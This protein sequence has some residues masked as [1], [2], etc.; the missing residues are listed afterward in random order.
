MFQKRLNMLIAILTLPLILLFLNVSQTLANTVAFSGGEL[1]GKP[2]D[3]SITINIVPDNAIQYYYEYGTTSGVY[4][5]ETSPVDAAAD[6]PHETVIDGLSSNT[7]YYYRMVYDGDGSVTDG[8]FETRDEHQFCTQGAKGESFVFTVTSDSHAQYNTQYQQ[9]MINV[10]SDNPDFHLD[11]GDTFMPDGDANQAAVDT[12]YMAQRSTLYMGRIGPSVPIFL[13]PGN[14]EDKEGWNLDDTPFSIG[15]GSIQARKAYFPTPTNEG[16]YSGNTDPLAAIDDVTYGDDLREDYYAWT[17]GDALFV[18]IDV[19]QYTMDLPYTP[20][21]GEGSDDPVTGDQWSWTLGETQYNWLK[22]T[23]EN[24]NARYKFV[25]SHNMVGGIPDN[26]VSGGAGYVRGGAEAAKYFE[27][28]GYNADGTT[29]AFD[30]ERPGWGVDTEHPNGTPI[31][32]LFIENGVSAYFH[33]HDHQYVYETRDGI[34]YQEVPSPSMTASAGFGG[35]YAEGTYSEYSTVEMLGNSGHLRISVDPT[36]ATVEYVS[37]GGISTSGTVNYTYEIEPNEVVDVPG[38]VVVDGDVS[39]GTADDVST[40]SFTHTTGTGDNRLM[41]VGVSWNTYN[42]VSDITSATF[43][44]AGGEAVPLTRVI[45]QPYSSNYRF[46]AIYGLVGPASGETGII[47]VNFS[48]SVNYGIV[49]GAVNFAGVDQVDPYGPIG[50]AS[51]SSLTPVIP[52]SDLNGDELVFDAVFYGGQSPVPALT[53]DV[54]QTELWNTTVANTRGTASLE[55]ATSSSI[56]MDWSTETSGIW[57]STAVALNPAPAGTTYDLT[58]ASDGHGTTDPEIGVHTY[59]ENAV[60]AINATASTG[61]VFDSWTGDADCADGSVTMTADKTCTATFVEAPPT[62][63]VTV[64]GAVSTGTADGTNTLSFAHTTG[65]GVNRLLLVGVTANSYNSAQ[66]ISSVTFSYG[67]TT[68]TLNLVGQIENEE[69]RLAA[70]YGFFTPPNGQSGTVTVTFSSTVNYGIVGGAVNFAGVDPTTPLGTF[71]SAT[72]QSVTPSVELT[73]LTGDEVVFDTVFLGGATIPTST[74][75][76][77]QDE[78]WNTS[79]DRTGGVAS[80]E[81]AASDTVTMSWTAGSSVYWSSAAVPINP[82]PLGDTFELTMASD[83][84]GTT[85]PAIGT[86]IYAENAVVAISATP[87]S[88]YEFYAWL[89]DSDCE[90]G[91]VT[92]DE[93][94][95][96]TATF[97]ELP[98]TAEVTVDGA[99]SSGTADDVD[100]LSFTHTT[101]TGDDRLM[102]V[103]ISWNSGTTARTISSVTFT[104]DGETALT[105][106]EVITEAAAS[107]TAPRNSAIY[108]LLGP[109][110]GVE[111]EV[112]VTFSGAVSNGI[113]AGAVN[114]AGVDQDDP[115]G[116]PDGA[117]A[118]SSSAPTVTLTGLNGD[119]LVFDNLFQGG[120]ADTQT[121]TPGADQTEQWNAFIGNTR[122]AASVEQAAGDSVTMSWTAAS[123]SVWVIAAVPINPA[124]LQAS[125]LGDVTGDGLI[126]S[127]DALIIL[128][129]DANLDTSEYC[130]CNCGDVNEDTFV[131][132]TDALIILSYDAG[133]TVTYPIGEAGCPS[134][135]NLCPGCV[136]DEP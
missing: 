82:A 101:G 66:T 125:V 116:E 42:A 21:A 105:L 127:T 76:A 33:G 19:F 118:S 45:L 53:V 104:P 132:S 95:T 36:V 48:G 1:L 57:V 119:E 129:C 128:S 29:W 67:S 41:L 54:S 73:G 28:G 81:A 111:G 58:M 18:V 94:K 108:S 91:S 43:T 134:N 30:T 123:T 49:A 35:I 3:T 44:P 17:W 71:A 92:M 55:Q 22:Q 130:P 39:T 63:D 117:T 112:T 11:L 38:T 46:A 102:L 113:V 75:G 64:D 40:I 52:L 65:T 60:V 59:A 96:C 61:Y 16:F 7:C 10:E 136:P 84:N 8:D 4:T 20:I 13:T 15:V 74:V 126:N 121:V 131:N 115:L 14:H 69:G 27:W 80:I 79:V 114:F 103:G 2:T 5:G 56:S 62:G 25:F 124:P 50:G 89:G 70:I 110:S 37:S 23:L 86:H 72:G 34:V 133:L 99:A 120:S 31:H 51:D 98:P 26:S 83:G 68:E 109:D 122:A 32:Q 106:D 85:I 88:G 78:L 77:D 6:Q 100:S 107:S 135:V 93:D 97:V 87:S 12:D 47:E 9:A 90:D 24:S